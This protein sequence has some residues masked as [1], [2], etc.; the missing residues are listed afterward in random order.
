[1]NYKA[2][3]SILVLTMVKEVCII[4]TKSFKY[5]F[6]SSL[7]LCFLCSMLISIFVLWKRACKSKKQH[8]NFKKS[9]N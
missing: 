3:I 8:T 4:T 6:N 1:M 2:N 5:L 9:C 7:I